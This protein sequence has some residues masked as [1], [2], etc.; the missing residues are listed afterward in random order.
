MEQGIKDSNIRSTHL[1]P[2]HSQS[3]QGYF[4]NSPQRENNAE[5]HNLL[6][7]KLNF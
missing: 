3:D 6:F 2:S 1:C 7:A 5:I 4:F